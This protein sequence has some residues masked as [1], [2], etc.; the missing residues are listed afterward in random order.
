M[1]ATSV[2][3]LRLEM[4]RNVMIWLLPIIAALFW[5]ITYRPALSHP[6]M[7]NVRAMSM[8][9]DVSICTITADF[10]PRESA[11]PFHTRSPWGRKRQCR[12]DFFTSS[13][14]LQYSPMASSLL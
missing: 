7:W 1:S 14:L 12:I 6:P 11:L 5:F 9:A 3:L 8:Q 4:R 2:R 10:F 13:T